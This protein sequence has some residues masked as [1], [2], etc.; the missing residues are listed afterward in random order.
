MLGLEAVAP[1]SLPELGSGC[2]NGYC[3]HIIILTGNSSFEISFFKKTVHRWTRCLVFGVEPNKS[4]R[5]FWTEQYTPNVQKYRYLSIYMYICLCISLYARRISYIH[6]YL[7]CGAHVDDASTFF[8]SFFL[9][10]S[11][12]SQRREHISAGAT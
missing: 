8:N 1:S 2:I 5:V 3:P 7:L 11:S 9:F 4:R 12:H 10:V 6:Y